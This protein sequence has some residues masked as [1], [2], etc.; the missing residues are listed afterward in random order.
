MDHPEFGI[1]NRVEAVA[2]A[3]WNPSSELRRHQPH[4]FVGMDV[5]SR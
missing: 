1:G 5:L 2:D 4:A 3:G